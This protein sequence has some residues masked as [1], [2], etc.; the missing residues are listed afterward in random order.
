MPWVLGT[1]KAVNETQ[2]MAR[3]LDEQLFELPAGLY[4]PPK[5]LRVFLEAFEGPLDLLLYLVKKQNLDILEVEVAIITEQYIGYIELA[6]SL[7]L[8]LAAEY[9]L[10]AALLAQIKSQK[11][12]PQPADDE[13]VDEEDPRLRLLEQLQTYERFR[14]SAENLEALPRIGRDLFS[15][16]VA[17]PKL[18][19]SPQPQISIEELF[20]ALGNALSR[21]DQSRHIV[22]SMERVSTKERAVAILEIIGG[23]GEQFIPFTSL[24]VPE[25]GRIGVV[26][27]FL[28]LLELMKEA[29]VEVVQSSAIGVI[30]VRAAGGGATSDY[31]DNH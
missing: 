12:L 7:Q 28:A 11:L 14:L 20:E 19:P 18:P 23:R 27:T 16:M 17:P 25:Q 5:A 24:C 29:L 4:I 9:L 3:V 10:M 22:I 2:V 26:A 8:D 21:A 13:E 31:Y 1:A 30:Q 15:V 6:Q